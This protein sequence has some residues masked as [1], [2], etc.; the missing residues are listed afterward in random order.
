MNDM[1]TRLSAILKK[2]AELDS[3]LSVAKALHEKAVAAVAAEEAAIRQQ[4]NMSPAELAAHVADL[5]PKVEAEL[6]RLEGVLKSI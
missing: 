3:K 2:K 4:F 6:T 5:R 1:A